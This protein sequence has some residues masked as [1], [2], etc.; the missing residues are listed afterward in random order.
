MKLSG[1]DIWN[2]LLRLL[3]CTLCLCPCL[4]QSRVHLTETLYYQPV[5]PSS[6]LYLSL[7]EKVSSPKSHQNVLCWESLCCLRNTCSAAPEHDLFL[8]CPGIFLDRK[9][10]KNTGKIIYK[11]CSRCFNNILSVCL[12]TVLKKSH[13]TSLNCIC[14]LEGKDWKGKHFLSFYYNILYTIQLI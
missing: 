14:K 4:Q 1:L 6:W 8:P 3:K 13:H 9:K 11:H 5:L 2:L 12:R 10:K 7:L